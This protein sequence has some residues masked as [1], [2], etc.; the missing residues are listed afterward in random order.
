MLWYIAAGT[1]IGGVSRYLLGGV[2][3]RGIMGFGASA[4]IHTEKV[5]RLSLD[6]PIVVEC[7]DTESGSRRFCPSSTE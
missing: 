5:L 4:G 6:L 2:V 1:A 3:Q 7:V